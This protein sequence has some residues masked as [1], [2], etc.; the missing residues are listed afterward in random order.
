M[1]TG[2]FDGDGKA[3]LLWRNTTDGNN[4]IW[5]MNGS[6]VSATSVIQAV[7]DLL[8]TIVAVGDYGGDGRADILWR[9]TSTGESVI[10][11]M[12]GFT[13]LSSGLTQA[14]PLLSLVYVQVDHLNTARVVEDELQRAVWRWDQQEP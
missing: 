9:N 14:A 2:D 4:A 8:W 12:D 6:T 10:W 13:L 11:F 3:D 1:G 5:L 7:V